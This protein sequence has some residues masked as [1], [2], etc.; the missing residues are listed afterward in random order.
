MAGE[1]KITADHEAIKKWVQE[2]G[3]TPATVKGTAGGAGVG[4]LRIRFESERQDKLQDIPW[5]EFFRK[6]DEKG[7]ALLYQE[8]T[9]S[10]QPSR[11]FKFVS[12]EAAARKAA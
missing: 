11:F 3:G 1:S 10:G 6:F 7:L 9:A 8:R 12:R 4:L 5:E 2:R